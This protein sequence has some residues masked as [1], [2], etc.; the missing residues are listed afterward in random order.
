MLALRPV[1]AAKPTAQQRRI[2]ASHG[3]ANKF[4]AANMAAPTDS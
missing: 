3:H 2:L 1:S 4:S